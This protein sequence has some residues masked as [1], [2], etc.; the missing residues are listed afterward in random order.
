MIKVEK[1]TIKEFRGIRDLSIDFKNKNFAICGRNGTG[2]S[3]IVD[4][5]EFALTGNITRLSGSGMG[6]ISLK[7][8]APHVD[9][10]DNP[11]KAEVIITVKILSL[12]KSVTIK[13]S[14]KEP[15]APKVT[16]Y[17]A[18]IA[19]VLNEVSSHPEFTLSRR[20]LI[21]YVI[22]APG[23]RAKEVQSLLRLDQVESLRSLLLKISNST[24]K[25]LRL[26][27]QE[28]EISKNQLVQAL[29]ITELT[30]TKLLDAVNQR[31]SIL[32][33]VNITALTPTTSIKDGLAASSNTENNIQISK[34]Q[35]IDTIHLTKEMLDKHNSA[36]FHDQI[37]SLVDN[38][39]K[40]ADDPAIAAGIEREQFLKTSLSLIED[41]VCPVCDTKW[42]PEKLK[43][44]IKTKLDNFDKL[45][46][47]RAMAEKNIETVIDSLQ[48]LLAPLKLVKE[49]AKTLKKDV[50]VELF[51]KYEKLFLAHINSMEK[52]I[53]IQDSIQALKDQADIPQE[54]LSQSLIDLEKEIGS[55]PDL[56]V[57]DSARDFLTISD[58]RL[59][60]Y[61]RVSLRCKQAEERAIIAR[62]VFDSYA[63]VSTETLNLI[64]KE[65]EKD[66]SDLYSYINSDDEGDFTAELKP[67]IGK[68][69]FEVDFYGRGYFP[70]GAYHSEG[71]QDGMGLCLYLALMQHLSG[72]NF[73]FAVLDD[74][75]MSVD[76]G[77]RREVC[78]LLK[79]KFPD[80]QFVLTTH[81]SVW[82]KHMKTVGLIESKGSIHFKK[83]CVDS[84]PSEWDNLDIWAEIDSELQKGDIHAAAGLLRHYLEYISGEI[85]H[86]LRAKVEF[87]GDGQFDLG[88]LLP[89]ATSRFV[90]LLS[91]AESA[92]KS[93]DNSEEAT[94][95]KERKDT[96]K[97]IN[98]KSQVEQWQANAAI[99]F[100]DWANLD[101][102]DFA[103]L[104]KIFH[105]LVDAFFCPE[106]K[107]ILHVIPAKGQKEMLKCSCGKI[108]L[109]LKFK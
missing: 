46:S 86:Y 102:K 44:A 79:E 58:D 54:E 77:H 92:A 81:D 64:Y 59:D 13:R 14:V 22:S 21:K 87:H 97:K 65:V 70:P 7:E 63:K 24:D 82:L 20:E 103:P 57:K 95:I 35:A 83:W 42:E 60:S 69:S 105:E 74:V 34:K 33:L 16:P 52:F 88:D 40:L 27:K 10:R 104:V 51:E 30:N 75:L 98:A 37:E 49:Y 55:L 38:L 108:S 25:E 6:S 101:K 18:E 1:I 85:C 68:L 26:L 45:A 48:E 91:D 107:S 94:S 31:R 93:W 53:P 39:K 32:G 78:K 99:H 50:V 109:N 23:D 12:N 11:D 62:K 2:K 9:S 84:G 41:G 17:N 8:H 96:F 5:I 66:F 80:T 15:S 56:A 61:R 71:H 19:S 36:E 47:E 100:N 73:T 89:S 4:A 43:Q 28:K 29:G 67:S 76:S 72:R 106:C 3:G 90:D